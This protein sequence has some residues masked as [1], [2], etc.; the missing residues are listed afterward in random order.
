MDSLCVSHGQAVVVML[1]YLLCL[2]AWLQHDPM[3][4][5]IAD[6]KPFGGCHL[7]VTALQP[8]E[9]KLEGDYSV[10]DRFCPHIALAAAAVQQAE[11]V[12]IVA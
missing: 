5:Q 12:H 3:F 11:S 8:Q 6:A 7:H 9:K 4:N 1:T 10:I 2:D